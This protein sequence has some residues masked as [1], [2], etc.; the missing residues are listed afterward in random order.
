MDR[1][2]HVPGPGPGPGQGQGHQ[3]HHRTDSRLLGSASFNWDPS[4]NFT[5]TLDIDAIKES[6]SSSLN[7]LASASGSSISA[8]SSIGDSYD[9]GPPVLEAHVDSDLPR[10]EAMDQ[11]QDSSSESESEECSASES[12]SESSSSSSSIDSESSSDDDEQKV[13]VTY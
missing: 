8:M 5:S 10:L 7:E 3:G 11:D 13:L 6:H 12:E 4:S 9:L 2:G 1:H